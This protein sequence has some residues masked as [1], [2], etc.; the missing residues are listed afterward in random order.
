MK[1]NSDEH[2]ALYERGATYRR[3]KA[4]KDAPRVMQAACDWL[5]RNA[6]HDNFFL[7]VDSFDPHE[8][9]DPPDHYIDLY[10]QDYEGADIHWPKYTAATVTDRRWQLID[11]PETD[12]R[13]L[14]DLSA[15]GGSL[16]NVISGNA[17]EVERLHR[18]LLDHLQR[19]DAPDWL[20]KVFREGPDAAVQP[21]PGEWRDNVRKRS[22]PRALTPKANFAD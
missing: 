11:F 20:R 10:S 3:T 4:E 16:R 6:G 7:W 13:Q 8:P 15:E 9:W 17:A 21:P 12:R 5:E 1:F 2:M 18:H 19:H 14:Y 22:T